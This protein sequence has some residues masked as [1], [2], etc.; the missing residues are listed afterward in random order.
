MICS[1]FNELGPTICSVIYVNIANGIDKYL[2][3]RSW[4]E[5]VTKSRVAV[6]GVAECTCVM[7]PRD[8]ILFVKPTQR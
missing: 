8:T 7:E 4:K 5:V 6:L 1:C 3:R 2:K